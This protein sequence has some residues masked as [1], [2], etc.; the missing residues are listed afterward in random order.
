MGKLPC[1]TP[2]LY[3]E[4]LD[5]VEDGSRICDVGIG[6]GACLELNME[7][8]KRKN[9]EIVGIDIDKEY[10]EACKERITK[11]NLNATAHVQDLLTFLPPEEDKF[12]HVVFME[13]FPVIPEE[14]MIKLVQHAC[15]NLLKPNGHLAMVHNLVRDEDVSPM[16]KFFK[17]YMK[18]V[19]FILCDFGR[20][21]SVSDFNN[22]ISKVG[23]KV[24]THEVLAQDDIYRVLMT[25]IGFSSQKQ[26]DTGSPLYYKL[27]QYFVELEPTR[28]PK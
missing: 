5:R 14:L 10:I 17:P 4:F 13:S 9:L 16:A 11:C 8:I 6:N 15:D 21:T 1:S 3:S 19:P 12:D 25:K 2:A 7:L 23:Y 24:T 20:L 27:E 22:F 26:T 28:S 18:W